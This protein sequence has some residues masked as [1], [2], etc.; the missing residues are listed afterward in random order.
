VTSADGSH[1]V[2]RASQR[3]LVPPYGQVDAVQ[4]LAVA[5]PQLWGPSTAAG[6]CRTA[7]EPRRNRVAEARRFRWT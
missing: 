5:Q 6:S 7:A 1:T 3:L 4:A 2:A